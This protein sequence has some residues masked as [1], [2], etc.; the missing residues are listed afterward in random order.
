MGKEV[1][2]FAVIGAQKAGTTS[3]FKYLEQHP[4]IY[5][6]KGKEAPFFSS[7]VMFSRGW[8]W[9]LREFFGDAPDD[10]Q[11]GTASPNYMADPRV[12]ERML[13]LLP[14]V[15]L[16]ALLRNP[17]DRAYSQYQMA[18]RSGHE[19]LAFREAIHG[20]LKPSALE[21]AREK[22]TRSNSYIVRGEYGRILAAF[23]RLFPAEHI[24]VFFTGQL[25][26]NPKEVLREVLDLLGVRSDYVPPD[27]GT[28]YH[29]GGTKRRLP[30]LEN[31]MKAD[32]LKD[33]W[34]RIPERYRQPFAFWLRQWNAIPDQGGLAVE[35]S[36]RRLLEEYFEED[37]KQLSRLLE[38]RGLR[39]PWS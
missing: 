19:T 6:P 27:L 4:D 36:V 10:S 26:H 7:D 23:C 8:K 9:Y 15:K 24:A 29:K 25:K 1:L 17:I 35:S 5:M 39:I 2:D 34:R 21:E 38:G 13:R 33:L 3:L 31:L 20:L 14:D 37:T 18:L 11:W 22:P 32:K 12:P 16:V 30:W 28:I